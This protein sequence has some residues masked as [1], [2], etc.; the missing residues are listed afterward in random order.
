MHSRPGD[1][2]S[3]SGAEYTRGPAAITIHCV[4]E[5]LQNCCGCSSHHPSVR[6]STSATTLEK[7][8]ICCNQPWRERKIAV[9]FRSN[10]SVAACKQKLVTVKVR[11]TKHEGVTAECA[12]CWRR[13]HICFTSSLT[14]T[15]YGLFSWDVAS[16]RDCPLLRHQRS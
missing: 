8:L 3:T 13:T 7:Q 9:M 5:L 1:G 2:I 12:A 6:Q 11:V 16:P 15:A 14:F 10:H 4:F